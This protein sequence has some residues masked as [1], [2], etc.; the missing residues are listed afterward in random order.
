MLLGQKIWLWTALLLFSLPY[1][2]NRACNLSS[3]TLNSSANLGGGVFQWTVTV[4]APGGCNGLDFFGACIGSEMND[5]TGNWAI[6]IDNSATITGF[7]P[8]LTSSQ[9]GGL[10]TGNLSSANTLITYTNAAQWWSFETT[11]GPIPTGTVCGTVTFTTNGQ[12]NQICVY[13]L[14]GADDFNVPPACAPVFGTTCVDLTGLPVEYLDFRVEQEGEAAHLYWS[15]LSEFNHDEFIVEHSTD[16]IRFEPV[17]N[18]P[19]AGTSATINQ[20]DHVFRHLRKGGNSFRIAA[21]DLSGSVYRTNTI[22][23]NYSPP[24]LTFD[25]LYPNPA[26]NKAHFEF[27]QDQ[28]GPGQLQL[29]DLNGRVIMERSVDIYAGRSTLDLEVSLIPSGTYMVVLQ[30]EQGKISSRLVKQ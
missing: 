5:N 18:L 29:I 14:E 2:T 26:V 12:P 21:K 1:S 13:G 27:L 6:G 4:C 8:T 25:R 7:T 22:T 11:A 28:S 9:T 16:G 24:G 15:T 10:F 30:T 20:Y 3:L 19:G 17:A 23:L